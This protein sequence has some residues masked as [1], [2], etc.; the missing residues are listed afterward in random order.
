MSGKSNS[1]TVGG[2][3]DSFDAGQRPKS[4]RAAAAAGND[5][6]KTF[7]EW[8]NEVTKSESQSVFVGRAVMLTSLQGDTPARK[9]RSDDEDWKS[10]ASGSGHQ[11]S[12]SESH[13]KNE[14]SG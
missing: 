1:C 2:V 13:L 7:C 6:M 8:L 14:Y 12:K 10:P 5:K 9:A 11:K 4:T 3:A